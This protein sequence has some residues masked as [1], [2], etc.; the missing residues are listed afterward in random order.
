[1][2]AGLAE[3]YLTVDGQESNR[4]LVMLSAD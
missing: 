3:L 1:L 2:N 4:V